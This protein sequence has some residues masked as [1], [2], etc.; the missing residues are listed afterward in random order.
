MF[1]RLASGIIN[2]FLPY[3][4]LEFPLVQIVAFTFCS[5]SYRLF[6]GSGSALSVATY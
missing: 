4:Q 3:I 2:N 5:M 1:Q 6:G